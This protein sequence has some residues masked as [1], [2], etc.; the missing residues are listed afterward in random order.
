MCVTSELESLHASY[1]V[2]SNDILKVRSQPVCVKADAHAWGPRHNFVWEGERE[3]EV[4]W[5]S[6]YHANIGSPLP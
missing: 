6:S 4:G 3:E 5:Y 2:Y 1:C